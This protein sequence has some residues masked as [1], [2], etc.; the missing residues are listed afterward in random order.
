MEYVRSAMITAN[1]FL[2]LNMKQSLKIQL[3][4]PVDKTAPGT[5]LFEK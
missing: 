4:I 2:F 3:K 5:F 1:M